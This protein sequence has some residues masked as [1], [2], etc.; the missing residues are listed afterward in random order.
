MNFKSCQVPQN[1]TGISTENVLDLYIILRKNDIFTIWIF[2]LK[3]MV[4]LYFSSLLFTPLSSFI[5]FL[6]YILHI[7]ILLFK[8]F[9]AIYFISDNFIYV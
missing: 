7:L 1:T 3:N 5:V 8:N 9:N 2:L 4:F 6:M